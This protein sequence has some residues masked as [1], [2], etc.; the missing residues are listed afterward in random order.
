MRYHPI[1]SLLH[2]PGYKISEI[3]TKTET[4]I[5]IRI[6][7]Y[8][9]NRG[10]CSGCGVCHPSCHSIQEMVAEDVRLGARQVFLYIPKRRYRC[11]QDGRIHTE[12][13]SWI[14]VG[15][16][17]TKVFARHVN[18]L[19]AITTNQE[20]GWY[21]GLND[22][23]VYR[24]DKALLER[25]AKDHLAPTPASTNI[26][27]DEVAWQKHHRYLTNVIDTDEKLV[28]WNA[29]GRKAE[30][31]GR[32]Y[33]SLG[34]EHCQKIESVALDG[35]RTYLSATKDYA[36]NAVI[37]LDRFHATQKANKAVDQ[38]RRDELRKARKNKD[39]ELIELANC[40]Q[41]FLLLKHKDKR[42]P[43]QTVT[44]ERLCALNESIYK[45]LILKEDFLQV[46]LLAN[47]EEA[48]EH[49]KTWI[50][51]ALKSGL[52]PFQELALSVQDKMQYILNWFQKRISSAISEGFN[53]K[54][55][56]LKRMAYG[57]R[58]VNYFRLKIHQHCG[59]LNPR[60]FQLN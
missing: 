10:K 34:P 16:R 6:A 44:L 57:Y 1:R 29:K 13:I 49:L 11:P 36:V 17:V 12:D 20:A 59:Y 14:E 37:V 35:A 7:P 46:Y 51:E 25:Y 50:T 8:K 54:I 45:G 32:Y 55:K 9:R 48:K 4:E 43:K 24:I 42:T 26:S 38:V 18:R 41:R 28:T 47:A 58:D 31:L 3:M 33:Q 23:K 27:V 40:K 21:L 56:R 19:T 53:N 52:V 60:R 2:I 15:A 22:E 30:V 5:H 39:T